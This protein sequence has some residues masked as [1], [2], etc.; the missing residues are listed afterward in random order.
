[1]LISNSEEYSSE[2]DLVYI[3]DEDEYRKI[4][5]YNCVLKLPRINEH[6]KDY[7]CK[8]LVSDLGSVYKYRNNNIDTDFSLNVTNSDSVAFLHSGGVNKV[9]LSCELDYKQV[10]NY[11]LIFKKVRYH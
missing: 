10:C 6:L 5:K 3:D 2:V 4:N 11:N 8:L 1:M 7:S 9:T